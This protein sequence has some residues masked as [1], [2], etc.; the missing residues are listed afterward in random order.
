MYKKYLDMADR[1]SDRRQTSNN[2]FL[3]L[4]TAIVGLVGYSRLGLQDTGFF[5][6]RLAWIISIVGIIICFVWYRM[7]RSYKDLNSGK[8]KVIHQIEKL[9]PIRPFDAEWDI[10]GRGKDRQLYLPFTHLEIY[11]PLV[12]ALLH[13][14]IIIA[15]FFV[16]QM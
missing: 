15:F 3:A 11:V 4:N 9:L 2:Y 13:L 5:L 12:F 10:L 7:V 16:K 6:N 14:G 8:F 1:I